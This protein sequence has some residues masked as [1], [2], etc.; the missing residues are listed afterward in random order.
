M[1]VRPM[2]F[3]V[4]SFEAEMFCTGCSVCANLATE[5]M[6]LS[7]SFLGYLSTFLH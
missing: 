5:E 7:F 2:M 4:M 6:V 1:F 3:A